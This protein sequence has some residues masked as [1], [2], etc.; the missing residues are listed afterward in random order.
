MD[1]AGAYTPDNLKFLLEGFWVTLQVAFISIILSFIIGGLVGIIRYAKVPV[2]SQILALI[3]ETVRNLPLLLIIFFTYFALPEIRIKLE[4]IPAAIVALTIFESAMLSEVI[5]SGLKSID[6]GQMEAARSSGLS[7]T[8]ALIHIILPQALRRMV[9]P[10]VSQ[11]ISLLKDTSLA[12]VISLP[13][14]THHGQI[15]YGQSQKYLI[16][17]LILVALMYFIVNY[18]LSLV[19]Q[20]LE[21][22]RT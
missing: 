17:I 5:R 1:F 20:R 14:L 9:P 19:A 22:K 4:I 2:L 12:V 10:I 16:P 3:V 11:F 13:E 18:S 21:L 15:I 6:K 8:Q 7:Y